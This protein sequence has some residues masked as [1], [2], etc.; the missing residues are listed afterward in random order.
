MIEVAVREGGMKKEEEEEERE[1]EVRGENRGS[2]FLNQIMSNFGS[3][4]DGDVA[5]EENGDDCGGGG[6]ISSFISSVFQHGENGGKRGE[7]VVSGEEER[8]KVVDQE[9]GGGGGVIS[10]LISN[11][12]HRSE[13]GSGEQEKGNSEEEKEKVVDD[14]GGGVIHAI[15][16]HIPRPLVGMRFL[17]Y[18][19]K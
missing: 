1:E 7:M 17:F 13:G 4:K 15:A 11:M 16:S 18:L 3:S 19:V 12:F 9:G 8:E 2:G 14:G 6:G 10:N 5:V